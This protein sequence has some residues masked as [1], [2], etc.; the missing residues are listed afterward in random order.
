MSLSHHRSLGEG[1]FL[2]PGITKVLKAAVGKCRWQRDVGMTVEPVV[3]KECR[4]RVFAWSANSVY[5][6]VDVS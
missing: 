5:K 6:L 2:W 1:G 3:C 4:K